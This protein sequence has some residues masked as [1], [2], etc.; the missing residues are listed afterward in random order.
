MVLVIIWLL[1]VLLC[2]FLFTVWFA[3]VCVF[4]GCGFAFFCFRL[5]SCAYGCLFYCC[6]CGFVVGL[7]CWLFVAGCGVCGGRFSAFLSGLEFTWVWVLLV[8]FCCV[9]CFWLF[10][11][12]VRVVWWLLLVVGALPLGFAMGV[13]G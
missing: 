4:Y 2:L 3:F 9:L 11:L 5:R 7:F 12:A 8:G 1:V 10:A 6:G 13:C